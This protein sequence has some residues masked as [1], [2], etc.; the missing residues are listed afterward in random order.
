MIKK[1]EA[2]NELDPYGEED[3]ND[4]PGIE[5]YRQFAMDLDLFPSN[6]WISYEDDEDE[7][8]SEYAFGFK[9][10]HPLVNYMYDQIDFDKWGWYGPAWM[11]N[12]AR[13]YYGLKHECEHE[14]LIPKLEQDNIKY[15]FFYE[16]EKNNF[17]H[18][19]LYSWSP[20]NR[21]NFESGNINYLP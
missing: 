7:D 10:E 1:F 5:E 21:R 18:Y 12:M 17:K 11:G 16:L 15:E 13:E 4:I 2:F 8:N 14:L 19:A 9:K 20:E 6:V 3:W